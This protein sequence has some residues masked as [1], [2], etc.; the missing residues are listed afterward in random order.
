MGEGDN[1]SLNIQ[2]VG[3]V[4]NVKYSDVKDSVPAVFY[5]PWRQDA[6]AGSL[7]YYVKGS[8]APEDMLGTLRT[9]MKRI[10]AYAA[11]KN[12]ESITLTAEADDLVPLFSK[13]GF[14]V[15]GDDVA[16]LDMK[17]TVSQ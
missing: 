6:S 11:S 12:C 1:D 15:E 14:E 7:N 3:V 10:D 4:R 17:K 16:S 13:Y 8:L 5:R 2:I 9:V